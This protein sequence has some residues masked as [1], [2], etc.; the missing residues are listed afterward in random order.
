ML[1][2]KMFLK[3]YFF[4]FRSKISCRGSNQIV[5]VHFFRESQKELEGGGSKNSVKMA[6]EGTS[7]DSAKGKSLQLEHTQCPG[8]STT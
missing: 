6:S 5:E 7:K 8:V 1:S 4:S 3:Y 2:D